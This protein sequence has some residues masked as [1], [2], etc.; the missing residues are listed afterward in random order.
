[1]DPAKVSAILNW[2]I[3]KSVKD[4]QSFLGFENFYRKFILHYSSLTSPLTTL[5]RKVV[6]FTWFEE[7]TF[8]QLQ[9]FFTSAP[10]L[11]HFQPLGWTAT[12]AAYDYKIIY[13]KGAANG[14]PDA[15]SRRPNYHP[16]PMW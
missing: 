10:I 13:R 16:P 3:P 6:K 1:M 15:L 8:R 7:A 14:K 2:S 12:M 4:V 9:Q 11:K 5:C